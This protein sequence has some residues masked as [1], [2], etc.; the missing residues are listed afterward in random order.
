MGSVRDVPA[1]DPAGP[2]SALQAAA[3]RALSLAALRPA[4]ARVLGASVLRSARRTGAW[5]VVST[6]ERA[7]GVAAMNL[8]DLDAAVTHLRA[9]VAA[10]RR[11]ASRRHVG[12]AR[13]SLASALVQRGH[14]GAA[15]HA[16]DAAIE[17]LRGAAA[18]RARVQ[19]AAILQE[20]GRFD[21]AL[22]ELRRTLPVL[23]QTGDVEWA[24]RALSNRSLIHGARRAFH[25]AEADLLD[26]RGLCVEHDLELPAAFAEQNLGCVK[27]LRG[28]VPAA[29]RCFDAA[30]A[31]YQRLGVVEP[32]LLVDRA[33]VLLSVRLLQ[34]AREAAESAVAA[35]QEQKRGVHVPEARL[36]LSTVALLQGDTAAARQS[37]DAAVRGFRRL[38]RT[39]SLALARYARLQAM[40]SAGAS[41]A[42]PVRAAAAADELERAGWPVPAL[43]ARVMA[44]RMALERGRHAAARRYLSRASRGRRAG[45]ADARA[46]AWMAEALLRRADG[47][48][49]A[50]VSALR[51]GLR[52]VEDH[53]A[54]LGAT[55]L[56]AHVSVQRGA[57]ARLGLSMALEDGS[58]R[59]AL[60]WAERGRA[61]ALLLRP[62]RPPEDADLA[63]DLADLRSTMSEIEE[64]RGDGRPDEPLVAR[65][66]ALERRIRDR[67]RTLTAGEQDEGGR[68]RRST[69]ELTAALGDAALVEYV[70]LAGRMHA[71]TLAGG[72]LRL[73]ALGRA[74]DVRRA[75]T[76]VP[77]A[78]HRL[79][80][81]QERSH[82]REAAAAAVLGRAATVVDDLLLR[83]LLGEVG[84]RE[85]VLSP[86]GSLQALP[87]SVLPSCR[88]RPVVVTPSATLWHRAATG[89][90]PGASPR[91]VVVAGPGLPGAASEAAAVAALH[92]GSALVTGD[93]ATAATVSRCVD[94][95]DLVHLAAHGTVRADNPLFS[96]LLLSDGPFTVY[97][98]ERLAQMPHHVVLA[99]CDAGRSHE[100]GG[101][102]VLGFGAALIGGG[103]A[104]FVA[105]VVAVPDAAT[106]PLMLAYHE[107]LRAGR[108]PARALA[109][110]Q[111]RFGATDPVEWVAAAAFVC[112]GAG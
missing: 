33:E 105:P 59:R 65:Q 81:P 34:E 68:R 102:E 111:V 66:V 42:G 21:A 47:R 18:A 69:D 51:A 43:D 77:F 25:A 7:V 99:A 89:H 9:A 63:R 82:G 12:E 110:A 16:I 84:D 93:A 88:G 109:A 35:Y 85:L 52:I 100:V 94:G 48:R 14:P 64:A 44:G 80:R 55:E 62:A 98:L 11:A 60:W 76:H 23:R 78:L 106:V 29:L 2:A 30:D 49:S 71:V 50:A 54:T 24:V 3:G 31:R 90:R 61:S 74:G 101:G 95:A 20:L 26:A 1:H 53:Q 45:P 67:C 91:V 39:T 112:L 46:R 57:L 58:P 72:R 17:D 108:T 41:A 4:D 86:T 13:M 79:A 8:G 75:L 83:P 96:S 107:G 36:L 92:P 19:R 22:D 37:A 38:G 10:G 15:V 73:H 103:T 70:E 87:W 56:R 6:G 40:A 5:D 32:S 28:D 27:A 104:T 97:E